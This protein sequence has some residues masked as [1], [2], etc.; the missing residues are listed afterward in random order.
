MQAARTAS[1]AAVLLPCRPAVVCPAYGLACCDVSRVLFLQDLFCCPAQVF[2]QFAGV[3]LGAVR[4]R[5]NHD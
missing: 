4:M 1:A 5:A 3:I 2:N